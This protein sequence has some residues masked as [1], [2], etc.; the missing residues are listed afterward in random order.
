MIF[1][2]GIGPPK[3]RNINSALESK[4]ML[5]DFPGENKNHAFIPKYYFILYE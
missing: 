5:K 1:L 3:Y 4:E 2:I